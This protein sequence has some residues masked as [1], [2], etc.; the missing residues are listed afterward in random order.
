[1]QA[2]KSNVFFDGAGFKAEQLAATQ[3]KGQLVTDL[4]QQYKDID[5]LIKAKDGSTKSVSVKDQ[6][7][8]SEKFGSIQVELNTINTRTGVSQKGCFYTNESDYYFWR[9]W[10]KE[11]G[12]TWAVIESS[13][14]KDFVKQNMDTLKPWS[15]TAKTEEKN[16]SYGRRYDR[17][18]GV[19]LKTSD[20]AALGK[21]IPVKG[22]KQ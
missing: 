5:V 20:I 2:N 14:L 13:V 8:S 4:N 18:T 7:W 21:L 6:L 9:I 11:H 15:T 19:V 10:T 22:T 1:M 17:T 16:R 3:F 12:D